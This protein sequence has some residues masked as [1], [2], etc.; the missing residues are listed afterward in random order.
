MGIDLEK[1]VGTHTVS[2]FKFINN[3]YIKIT[4][5]CIE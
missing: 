4:T 3:Y 2:G 5:N 1:E